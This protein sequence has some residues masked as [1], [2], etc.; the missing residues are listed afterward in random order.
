[1]GKL[2]KNKKGRSESYYFNAREKIYSRLAELPKG[3]IKE[4]LISGGKYY[5]LQ[6][7]EGKKVRHT[8]IGKEIPEDLKKQFKE[9][10]A[11]QKELSH[12]QDILRS[13]LAERIKKIM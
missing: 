11:L 6:R 2:L 13:F 7:R 10:Q 4:R 3:T 9:R 8:Y 1:M 5:Y 12:V